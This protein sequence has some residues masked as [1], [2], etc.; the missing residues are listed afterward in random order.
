MPAAAA[1]EVGVSVVGKMVNGG[2]VTEV[3]VNENTHLLKVFQCAVNRAH[4]HVGVH[5]LHPYG[6]VLGG[7]MIARGHQ[8]SEHG[9]TW[10]GYPPAGVSELL[11]DFCRPGIVVHPIMIGMRH[12]GRDGYLGPARTH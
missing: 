6:E 4:R 11:Q 7:R 5:L 1:D 12:F 2:T 10:S 8:R 9:S 3:Y